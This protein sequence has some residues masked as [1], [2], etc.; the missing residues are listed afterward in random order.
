MEEIFCV[1]VLVE[2]ADDIIKLQKKCNVRIPTNNDVLLCLYN[3][4]VYGKS[5]NS[6]DGQPFGELTLEKLN[7]I[8]TEAFQLLEKPKKILVS[9][10]WTFGESNAVMIKCHNHQ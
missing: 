7:E 1:Y 6:T 8:A 4:V 2:S 3:G 10:D 5:D 9:N